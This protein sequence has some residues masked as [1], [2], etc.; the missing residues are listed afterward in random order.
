MVI[1]PPVRS[2]FE[3]IKH[4]I[5]QNPEALYAYTVMTEYDLYVSQQLTTIA[6]DGSITI[7]NSTCVGY[8]IAHNT[9][10][11]LQIIYLVE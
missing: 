9:F 11:F 3:P 1:E 5:I 7:T 2:P 4:G 8:I 10:L 6:E